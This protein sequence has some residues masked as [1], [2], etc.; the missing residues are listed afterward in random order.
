MFNFFSKLE[1]VMLDTLIWPKVM[2][3]KNITS[4]FHTVFFRFEDLCLHRFEPFK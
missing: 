4:M 2:F 3:F 1:V